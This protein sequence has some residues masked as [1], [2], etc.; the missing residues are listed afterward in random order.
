MKSE[1]ALP[2]TVVVLTRDEERNLRRCLRSVQGWAREVFVVDSG[3]TDRTRQV[4]DAEGAT[5]VEHEFETHARQWAWAL[6]H[7]P[8]TSEWVLGLDADQRVMPELAEELRTLFA[9]PSACPATGVAGYYV[10]RRQ[11]F[12][13]RWIRHGG[14]YPKLLLKLFRRDA[15]HIDE[16]D[17]VDHHFRVNGPVGTLRG[18]IIEANVNEDDITVWIG[19]HT[20]Y[21]TLQA[22]ESLAGKN[23]AHGLEPRLFGHADERVLWWKRSL[24]DRL[25]L[26]LRP[27]LYFFYRYVLRLGFLDGK[28]GFL[29]HFLQAWWYR[30]LVDVR[31]EEL[32]AGADDREDET[33]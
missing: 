29:F 17:L 33:R 19:K 1:T 3:S 16:A 21:A 14:Y 9:G 2:I 5:V 31:I 10:R 25:P 6:E 27:A 30:L 4:A 18:D 22:R 12:R 23:H 15:V 28:E 20:R 24:W 32:R 13:G 7:L 11:I 26:Y 8:V